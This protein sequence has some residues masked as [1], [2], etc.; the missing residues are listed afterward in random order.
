M[1]GK[2]SSYCIIWNWKDP[3]HCIHDK[4]PEKLGNLRKNPHRITECWKY[5]CHKVT[6]RT[7]P[8]QSYEMASK[9][10]TGLDDFY[11]KCV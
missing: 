3:K 10:G 7:D 11:V 1:F 6:V 9:S 8:I 5:I 4:H 2:L